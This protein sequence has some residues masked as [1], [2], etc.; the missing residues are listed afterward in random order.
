MKYWFA[1]VLLFLVLLLGGCQKEGEQSVKPAEMDME[2][3]PDV[4]AFQDEFTR[5]FL[6]STE[7]TREG[8][9]PF[10]SRTREYKM[11]FPAGG[12]VGE[13]GY[14]K[15]GQEFE[16][17]LAGVDEG[18]GFEASIKIDYY[19]KIGT[20]S[21]ELG[22]LSKQFKQKLNFKKYDKNEN[23][24][25]L[26]NFEE[27]EKNFGSVALLDDKNTKRGLLL[28]YEIECVGSDEDCEIKKKTMRSKVEKWINSI[29]FMKS[30]KNVEAQ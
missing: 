28:I 5:G 24:T 1:M 9:Y 16:S 17:Y 23:T 4:R 26:A 19:S 10:M 14:S 15:K 6:L 18:N 21:S 12:I 11:D 3:L 13:K 8:Y 30:D 20:T 29:K 2:D 27:D 22:M 25:Y 7:E